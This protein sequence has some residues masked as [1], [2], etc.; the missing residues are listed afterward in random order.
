MTFRSNKG[1]RGERGARGETAAAHPDRGETDRSTG[2]Y[3]GRQV[4]RVATS[5]DGFIVLVGK[6]ATDNDVV[7]LKLGRP[8]D[9]WLHASGVSGSHVVVLNDQ[10]VDRLPKETAQFAA[11]LAAGYSKARAGG[12]VAV[13]LAQC[14]DVSKP[15]GA[16]PGKVA[17]R[18]HQTVHAEPLRLDD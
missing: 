1:P 14:S 15:R 5:P 13:H 11:G 4:A 7:S 3:G 8:Y 6:T 16:A 2:R 12:R 18:R 9:F 17:L 10:R